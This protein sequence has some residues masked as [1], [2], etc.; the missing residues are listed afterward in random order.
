M[1][2]EFHWDTGSRCKLQDTGCKVQGVKKKIKVLGLIVGF[3][4]G[5]PSLVTE[6]VFYI[7]TLFP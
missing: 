5:E 7:K 3:R 2:L 4:F 1:G 6:A